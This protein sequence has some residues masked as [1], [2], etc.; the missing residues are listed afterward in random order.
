MAESGVTIAGWREAT[1]DYLSRLPSSKWPTQ[2][3]LAQRLSISEGFL[4]ERY[5]CEG[6]TY[7][8]VKQLVLRQ[9]AEALLASGRFKLV[10]EVSEELG[11]SDV[12]SFRR[13][14]K[15]WTGYTPSDF[16]KQFHGGLVAHR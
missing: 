3:W 8:G 15:K 1:I 9:R 6:V 2:R 11:F 5:Y 12:S 7:R 10:V 14:F 4:R 13:S 16:L